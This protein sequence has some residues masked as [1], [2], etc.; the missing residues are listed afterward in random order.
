MISFAH[1]RDLD[2]ALVPKNNS[3]TVWPVS[4]LAAILL[5]GAADGA[6]R[7]RSVRRRAKLEIYGN[8]QRAD[9][10]DSP[11]SRPEG[12][13]PEEEEEEEAKK[14]AQD[15]TEQKRQAVKPSK[16]AKPNQSAGKEQKEKKSSRRRNSRR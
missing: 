8:S 1:I 14:E 12:L 10:W 7:P 9:K 13:N 16:P 5:L 11:D 6:F 3:A 15:S 4:V 2:W